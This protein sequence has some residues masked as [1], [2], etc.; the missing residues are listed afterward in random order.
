MKRYIPTLITLFLFSFFGSFAVAA[1][2]P[3]MAQA[4]F[5]VR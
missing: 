4:V 3:T 1:E 2:E 5:Y